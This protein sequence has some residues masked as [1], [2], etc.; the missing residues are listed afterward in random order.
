MAEYVD[1]FQRA[2]KNKTTTPKITTPDNT[3]FGLTDLTDT[4]KRI[5][6]SDGV[7]PTTPP[8]PTPD[9]PD[10]PDT[11]DDGGGK[12]FYSRD[13]LAYDTQA[14][15]DARNE[16]LDN[17]DAKDKYDKD[18]AEIADKAEKE[19][20]KRD[21]FALI[22]DTMRSYGFTDAEMVELQAFIE[23]QII[24][25]NIGP[26]AG[27]LAMKA[28][29][30][31]KAR[32]AGNESRVKSGLNALSEY[33]YLQQENAYG[34]YLQA[35]GVGNLGTRETYANLIA[36]QVSATEVSKRAQIAVDRVKN[37]DPQIMAQLKA[38]YPTLTDSDLVSYFLNPKQVLPDLERKV[39]ASEIS[40]AAIG[41]G[42]KAGATNALGLADY[43]IDR[44]TALTGYKDIKEVLPT[45][46]KLSNVY[47]ETGIKYDQASAENEFLKNN[48]DVA[49][50]RKRLKSLERGQFGGSAGT[51]KGSFSTSYLNKQSSAGQF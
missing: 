22:N 12:K 37:S 17:Q 31:Y 14:Q 32:F 1:A 23:S 19:A 28:L 33:D 36:N 26:Q 9:T 18:Q 47:K 38:Y 7:T 24:D 39:T 21:A 48:V 43:G 50:Q 16:Y 51:S 34:Q 42:F 5:Y 40:A 13:G 11:P 35:Y 27:I 30:V 2:V 44:A 10:E 29:P 49:N 15:A 4:E 3:A 8:K 45:T 6:G 20:E 46:Q 41:Q 25:P